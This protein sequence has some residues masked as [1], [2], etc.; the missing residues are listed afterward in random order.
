MTLDV[1]ALR[2]ATPGCEHVVHLNNAGTSLPAAAT[3]DAVVDHLRL[4]ATIGGYEAHAAA[5]PALL[6]AHDRLGA[7]VGAAGD[8]V[9]FVDNA[10]RAWALVVASID[11][12]PGD[13]V[14][15]ARSEYGSNAAGLHRLRERA[16]VETIVIDDADDGTVD[17]EALA[18][19][20]DERVRLVSLTHVP[21]TNGLVQPAEA[22]GSVVRDHP[23]LFLLDGAQSLGQV[24]VDSAAIGC[25]VVIGTARKYLRGP[26]GV[27]FLVATS[28]V[29]RSLSPDLP[30]LSAAVRLDADRV[31][32]AATFSGRFEAWE[33]A[34]AQRV[35]FAEALDDLHRLG[36]EVVGDRIATLADHLRA[37]LDAVGGVEVHDRG[38]RRAGIVT[39]EV[40]GVGAPAV[41]ARLREAGVNTSVSRAASTPFDPSGGG[42]ER[43]RASVH[44]F[45]TEEELDSVVTR[46]GEIRPR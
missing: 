5:E 16:G 19:S 45:N 39:F 36:V 34:V 28:D 8:D 43:V 11:W 1:D 9:A 25:D 35:G 15:T 23:A 38:S 46:V 20:L 3:V 21:G 6:A 32:L 24:P 30:Q 22:V 13:R 26:R 31:E 18:A 33:G 7:V 29:G 2:A 40:D 17:V 44:A 12:R 41:V 27:G 4:E 42:W 10:S 14:L 37:G